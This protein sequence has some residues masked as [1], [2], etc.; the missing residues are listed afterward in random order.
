MMR[1]P[2]P[3]SQMPNRLAGY[4]GSL[5]DPR[6]TPTVPPLQTTLNHA[7]ITI[8][9]AAAR[10]PM[11]PATIYGD[12]IGTL[13]LPHQCRPAGGI[14]GYSLTSTWS[15]GVTLPGHHSGNST[16]PVREPLPSPTGARP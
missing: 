8:A 4:R 7:N 12:L 15:H 5:P 13:P 9:M 3:H 11:I 14:H 1:R 10:S 16:V 6:R 2:L